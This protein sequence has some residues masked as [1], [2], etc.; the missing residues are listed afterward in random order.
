MIFGTRLTQSAE[1]Q[2]DHFGNATDDS[3]I[4]WRVKRPIQYQAAARK[5]PCKDNVLVGTQ[6][7]A[8]RA[9]LRTRRELIAQSS[10][11]RGPLQAASIN[12][13]GRL[14]ELRDDGISDA[15]I[16]IGV[17]PGAPAIGL[18]NCTRCSLAKSPQINW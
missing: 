13:V 5:K 14:S 16:A 12:G 3:T 7:I 15:S 10:S 2:S 11:K 18:G 4:G 17:T 8:F 1:T 6:T 9:L